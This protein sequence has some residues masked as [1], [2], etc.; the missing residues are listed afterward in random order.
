MTH[1][2]HSEWRDSNFHASMVTRYSHT[3][4]HNAALGR[5]PFGAIVHRNALDDR[6]RKC[7]HGCGVDETLE[8]VLLESS[9]V[10]ADRNCLCGSLQ[11]CGKDLSVASALGE[12][13][14][15]EDCEKLL[16]SFLKVF[17]P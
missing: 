14:V 11:D 3:V 5:G 6:L 13:K 4:Y 10:D 9:F 16:A 12:K 7:R 2:V 17:N 8:H 15:S 1:G